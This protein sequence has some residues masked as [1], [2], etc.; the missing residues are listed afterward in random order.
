MEISRTRQRS[1]KFKN[2]LSIE[3]EYFYKHSRFNPMA[4]VNAVQQTESSNKVVCG[5]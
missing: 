4:M 5:S 3:D 2:V 1:D